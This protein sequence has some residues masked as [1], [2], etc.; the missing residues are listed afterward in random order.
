MSTYLTTGYVM[1]ARP[2]RERDRLYTVL[3]DKYGKINL[4]ATGS[5]KSVS[6]LAGH[7]LPFAQVELMVARGKRL[8]HLATARLVKVFLRPPYHLP[9]LI[10]GQVMVEI[11]DALTSDGQTEVELTDLLHN[12]WA[13]L[14]NLSNLD[15][16]WRVSARLLL[17]NY[18]ADLLKLLGLQVALTSCERCKEKLTDPFIYS[19]RWHGFYHLACLPGEENVVKAGKLTWQELAALWPESSDQPLNSS[20]TALGFLVN[21]ISGQAGRELVTLKLLRNLLSYT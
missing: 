19:W 2:W 18:C 20:S 10:L 1:K 21:Y 9:S 5:Q 8:D 14:D 11:M 15:K 17:T 4:L 6:K 12:Y 13:N 3:T 7:L 16:D